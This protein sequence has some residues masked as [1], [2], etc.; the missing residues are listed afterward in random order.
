MIKV[1]FTRGFWDDWG[2]RGIRGGVFGGGGV[3]NGLRGWIEWVGGGELGVG[4]F[5][6]G[7]TGDLLF[8]W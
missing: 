2:I 6:R 1:L 3:W 8:F 7:K 5:L 4:D